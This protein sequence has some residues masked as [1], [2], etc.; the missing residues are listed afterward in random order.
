MPKLAIELFSVDHW[1]RLGFDLNCESVD[2][3]IST[4]RDAVSSQPGAPGYDAGC[5]TATELESKPI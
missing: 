1:T 3:L 5:G 4:V 2:A